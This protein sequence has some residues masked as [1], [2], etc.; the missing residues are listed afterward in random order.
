MTKY[1][2]E[3]KTDNEVIKKALELVVKPEYGLQIEANAVK[4]H[5]LGLFP[6]VQVVVLSI[7]KTTR[8]RRLKR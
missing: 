2:I 5:I 6:E 4:R 3:Y 1:K 7:T 8:V